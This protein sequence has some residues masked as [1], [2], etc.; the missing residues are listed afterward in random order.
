MKPGVP[1]VS[2]VSHTGL[3]ETGTETAASKIVIEEFLST[4][5]RPLLPYVFFTPGSSN[6]QKKYRRLSSAQVEQFSM[7]NFYNLDAIITYCHLLNIIGKRMIDEPEATITLTGCT[8]PSENDPTLAMSRARAVRD[9]LVQTW[10]IDERRITLASRGLP[11]K[12]SRSSESDG[13]AEN[14]RVEITSSSQSVI[15]PVEST[16]TMK[17]CTPSAIRFVPSI[18]PRVQ[19]GSYTLFIA[20]QGS[21]LKTFGGPDPLPRTIDWRLSESVPWIPKDATEIT[22]LLAVRDTAGAVVPS[23]TI[24]IP[25]E[26]ISS[27]EKQEKG[28]QNIRVDRYSL[29]LFGFDQDA[30]TPE[31]MQT[32]EVIKKRLQPNST[33]RVI[34]YTDR[35]GDAEYNQK[36]SERRARAVAKA[37]GLAESVASG[38]G[39]L[40][41]LYD[42]SSPEGRFYSRTVEVLVETPQ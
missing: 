17:V 12:A 6:L 1:F 5:V 41:P 42:N 11:S 21:L 38:R 14:A 3:N 29:I 7:S 23:P 18:D 35:S 31:H 10:D 9:Y 25:I 37:L 36:L 13:V 33:V 22:Y 2:S 19:I 16:D 27:S 40:L 4:R 26:H 24:S 30:L 39:E 8:D 32:I 15:A 34:G 28:G 20:H